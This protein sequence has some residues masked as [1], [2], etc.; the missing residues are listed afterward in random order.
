M[1][2]FILIKKNMHTSELS[3]NFFISN[4]VESIVCT[5][6]LRE[7]FRKKGAHFGEKHAVFA[8]IELK[9]SIKVY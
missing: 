2:S 7:R 5:H 3:G 1:A 6:K 9:I 4:S 8:V